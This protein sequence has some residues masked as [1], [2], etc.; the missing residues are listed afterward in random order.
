MKNIVF[1]C[2]CF[3]D[4]AVFDKISSAIRIRQTCS[5]DMSHCHKNVQN[6]IL[7]TAEEQLYSCI[8][9]SYVKAHLSIC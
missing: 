8:L 3:S 7:L 5:K 1:L 4:L 2:C 6:I 9:I